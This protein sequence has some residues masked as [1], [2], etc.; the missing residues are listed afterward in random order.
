MKTASRK[1]N[2]PAAGLAGV[3]ARVAMV[4]GKLMIESAPGQGTTMRAEIPFRQRGAP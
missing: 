3:S 2:Q 4:G 1:E